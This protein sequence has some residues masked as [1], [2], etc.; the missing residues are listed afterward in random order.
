MKEKYRR[1]ALEC[2]EKAHIILTKKEKERIGASDF[3][4]G[5]FEQIGVQF[6]EYVSSN[7]VSAKDVYL[8]PGQTVPEHRHPGRDCRLGKEETFRCRYGRLYLYVEGLPSANIAGTLPEDIAQ[9]FTVWHEIILNPG[10][11]YTIPPDTLHWFQ[12]GPEGA[13]MSEFATES[14]DDI[15]EFTM[16]GLKFC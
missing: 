15:D 5:R 8:L 14:T 6:V 10:E 1:M 7:R 4:L 2:F 16:P 13:I 12:G 3:G 11:Q 9:Y